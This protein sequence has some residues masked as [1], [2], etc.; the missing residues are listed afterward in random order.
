MPNYREFKLS[1]LNTPE[2]SHIKLLIYWPLYGIAFLILERFLNVEYNPVYCQLDDW[3]P[4]CEYFVIPYYFWF[5]FLIGIQVYGFFFDVKAFKDYMYYT[6]LTY[7][8]TVV[9]YIIYPTSQQLRPTEFAR[10]NVFTD[11]VSFLYGFDTNTNVCPSLHV[12]GSFA[13]YFAARKSKA[14]SGPGWRIAFF[15]MTVLISI[16]TVF[17]KQHSVLDI[18]WA[19]ILCA[20]CY[21]VVFEREK[22]RTMIKQYKEKQY[23]RV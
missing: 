16:S 4:F 9:I 15:V 18:F 11:I 20:V 10:D 2:F 13:V 12:I 3:I 8:L 7:T 5:I 22:I 1:K 19:I 6:I 17:L 21:P 23:T 14:F